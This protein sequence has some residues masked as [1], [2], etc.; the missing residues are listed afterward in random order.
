MFYACNSL[1]SLD[2][3]NFDT[4]K[5]TDMNSMFYACNSLTSL[6]VSNFDTS[7]VGWCHA[8]FFGCSSLVELDLSNWDVSNVSQCYW[9]FEAC[10]SLVELNLSNWK[11]K[12]GVNAAGVFSRCNN[13][14][15]IILNN[16]DIKSVNIVIT[17][18][19]TRTTLG[20]MY[21]SRDISS[22]VDVYGAESKMWKII[23]LGGPIK[24]VYINGNKII[25]TIT[26]QN[27]KI[28][29]IYLGDDSL[30]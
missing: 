1:T 21:I 2:V 24:N 18:L 17:Q 19:P 5:V 9:M 25:N 28:K 13:L 4:S 26:G 3:S 16:S 20:H 6:D 23:A 27:K 14:K 8:A 30:L 29:G 12:D 15:Y 11:F 10:T 7:K 22:D